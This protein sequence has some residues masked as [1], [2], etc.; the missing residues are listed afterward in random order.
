MVPGRRPEL[1]LDG[2]VDG[3][4]PALVIEDARETARWHDSM[5][6]LVVMQ[7]L[8]ITPKWSF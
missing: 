4:D 7:P 6:R 8:Y 5:T 2:R 3:D 1:G